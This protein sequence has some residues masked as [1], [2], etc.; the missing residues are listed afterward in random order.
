MKDGFFSPVSKSE[1][2]WLDADTV[3]LLPAPTTTR[4]Q[5]SSGYPRG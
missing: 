1:L 3:I 2:G 5:T 4:Q